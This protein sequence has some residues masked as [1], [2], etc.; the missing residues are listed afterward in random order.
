MN[1]SIGGHGLPLSTS[2]KV[3]NQFFSPFV[4]LYALSGGGWWWRWP[5]RSSALPS[6]TRAFSVRPR[7]KFASAHH[8][9]SI[10]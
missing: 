3:G 4:Q 6:P 9:V 10:R 8:H 1:K 5:L 2:V 7:S